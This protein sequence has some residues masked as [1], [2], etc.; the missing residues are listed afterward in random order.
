MKVS[1]VSI[2]ADKV[3][4]GALGKSFCSSPHPTE[5]DVW[6]RRQPDHPDECSAFIHSIVTP[7]TW[8]KQEEL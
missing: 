7:E 3:K 8:Y 5:G 1:P 6:C 4:G 2:V